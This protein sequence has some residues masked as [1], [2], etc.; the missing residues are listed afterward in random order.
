MSTSDSRIVNRIS[1]IIIRNGF[2]HDI[3]RKNVSD[4]KSEHVRVLPPRTGKNT[5]FGLDLMAQAVVSTSDSEKVDRISQI[6]F[7]NG[8]K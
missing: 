5:L 1:K 2:K 8:L 7:Y 3:G 4:P 6:I